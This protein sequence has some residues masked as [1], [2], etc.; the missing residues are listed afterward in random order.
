[1]QLALK[2]LNSRVIY[3]ADDVVRQQ[4]APDGLA[5]S[6][7]RGFLVLGG[8]VGE[9]SFSNQTG[10][11][12]YASCTGMSQL[13]LAACDKEF[14]SCFFLIFICWSILSWSGWVRLK[15]VVAALPLRLF[16]PV[17]RQRECQRLLSQGSS[18]NSLSEHNQKTEI[19]HLHVVSCS[20][21]VNV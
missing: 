2:R 18:W 12:W 16:C 1:M 4:A 6:G 21:S 19:K 5:Y 13:Q 9:A 15:M 10:T 20:I 14:R 3:N 11:D 7:L 17:S 8:R